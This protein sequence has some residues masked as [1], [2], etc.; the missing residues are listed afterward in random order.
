[1]LLLVKS[2]DTD[3]VWVYPVRKGK[4]PKGVIKDVEYLRG[5]ICNLP[6]SDWR[7]LEQKEDDLIR[8]WE[9]FYPSNVSE[10]KS[11]SIAYSSVKDFFENLYICS[12]DINQEEL[13]RLLGGE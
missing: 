1:M 7:R 4:I 6:E 2:H 12:I 10:N 11:F 5:R 3:E 8:F 13:R 9:D